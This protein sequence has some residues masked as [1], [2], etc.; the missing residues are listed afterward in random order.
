MKIPAIKHLVQ[1]YTLEQLQQAEQDLLE[2][3]PLSIE[4]QG[5]DEGEQLT[6]ILAG[7][8]IHEQQKQDPNANLNTLLRLYAEKVRKSID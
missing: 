4:V 3:N 2:G 5:E 8:W 1:N 6:H 7:I